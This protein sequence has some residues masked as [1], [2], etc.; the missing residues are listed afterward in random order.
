M[1]LIG[2]HADGGGV[3]PIALWDTYE[4]EDLMD[5]VRDELDARL[6]ADLDEYRTDDDE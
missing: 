3:D 2:A 1:E 5:C 4:L 6:Q